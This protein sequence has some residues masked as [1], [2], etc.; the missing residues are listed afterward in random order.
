MP[1][2]DTPTQRT[3][4]LALLKRRGMTRLAEFREAG[5]TATTNGPTRPTGF[6]AW[7]TSTNQNSGQAASKEAMPALPPR[8]RQHTAQTDCPVECR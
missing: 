3:D 5:I 8:E 4:A 1:A 2:S 7:L 6:G